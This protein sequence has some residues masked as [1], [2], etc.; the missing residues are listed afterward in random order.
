M[1]IKHGKAFVLMSSD[2]SNALASQLLQ[3][4]FKFKYVHGCY[5]GQ[6]ETSLLIPVRASELTTGLNFDVAY[7][8]R[9]GMLHS[10]QSILFVDQ[11]RDAHL[12]SCENMYDKPVEL[13]KFVRYIKS[14]EG[15]DDYTIDP[16]TGQVWICD[17]AA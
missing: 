11:W 8:R 14:V 17:Q 4:G 13:G 3:D 16:K 2:D 1:K 7:L 10:Q 5:H 15:L 12:Y 9:L 6:R